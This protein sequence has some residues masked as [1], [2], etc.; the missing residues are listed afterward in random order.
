MENPNRLYDRYELE[1]RIEKLW[2]QNPYALGKCLA[3]HAIRC[4]PVLGI[5]VDPF[6]FWPEPDESTQQSEAV[7]DLINS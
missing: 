1:Q 5:T 2:Q 3:R 7:P 6:S 4:L